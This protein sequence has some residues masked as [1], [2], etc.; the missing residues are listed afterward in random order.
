MH[1]PPH[2]ERE[3]SVKDNPPGSNTGPTAQTISVR[4]NQ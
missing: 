4:E 1:Y 2:E 3:I